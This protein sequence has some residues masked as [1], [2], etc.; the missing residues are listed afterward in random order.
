MGDCSSQAT[1]EQIN[2]FKNCLEISTTEKKLDI[3]AISH[4]KGKAL[5]HLAAES[6]NL[7]I[8]VMLLD[9]GAKPDVRTNL[10]FK[11]TTGIL[12]PDGRTPLHLAVEAACTYKS[13]KKDIQRYIKCID[14]LMGRQASAAAAV[15]GDTKMTPLMYACRHHNLE[16]V[17][18]LMKDKSVEVLSRDKVSRLQVQ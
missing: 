11:A 16:L 1:Q 14:M 5:L 7:E 2:A 6:G 9:R 10:P 4:S 8:M 17:K 13:E 12:E 3:N 15:V 18:V